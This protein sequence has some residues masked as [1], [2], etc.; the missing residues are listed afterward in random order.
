MNPLYPFPQTT[1]DGLSN[2]NLTGT[3]NYPSFAPAVLGTI[4]A[5]SK[6][7][8]EID[9]ANVR[10]NY[11]YLGIAPLGTSPYYG[12]DGWVQGNGLTVDNTGAIRNLGVDN[13]GGFV[14]FGANDVI[15]FAYDSATRELTITKNGG[16]S[17]TFTWSGTGPVAPVMANA[18]DTIAN[19]NCGQQPFRYT[20]PAGFEAL[21]T[22]NMPTPAILDGRD[23]FQAITGP[24]QGGGSSPG[25]NVVGSFSA[26]LKRRCSGAGIRFF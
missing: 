17:N 26:Y 13:I 9:V 11:P 21:Q 4:E 10:Y 2:A 23:H 7:Y 14:T 18:G 25:P 20:P 16:D 24:G 1:K 15:G 5:T 6:V 22:Q 19:I 8:W 3:D 12:G